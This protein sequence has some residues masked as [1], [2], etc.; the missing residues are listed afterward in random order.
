MRQALK[1]LLGKVVGFSFSLPK[2]GVIP[3]VIISNKPDECYCELQTDVDL[4]KVI[5]NGIVEYSFDNLGPYLDKLSD[6]QIIALKTKLKY[7]ESASQ[8]VRLKYGFFGEVLLFLF[9]Q[10]FH[11]ADT[12]IS[13]GWFYQPTAKSEV[14]GYDTYQIVDHNNGAI[15]LWFGEVKFYQSYKDAIKKILDKVSV[16]LSDDYLESNILT[17]SQHLKEVNPR[18]KIDTIIQAWQ[19][20]PSIVIKDELLKYNMTLVYPMLVLFDDGNKAYDDVIKEVVEFINSE[21]PSISY[22][23]AVPTKLFFM[24]LPV[25][26]AKSIKTQVL[27]WIDTKEALI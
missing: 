13:R 16:S 4:A 17:I 12:V 25:N 21:Y 19:E 20:N 6:A 15:D 22:S 9:L 5:Y 18:S 11:N 1:D 27:S 23:I 8:D 3:K 2:D 24:L 7:S 26:S 14:T 10:Y